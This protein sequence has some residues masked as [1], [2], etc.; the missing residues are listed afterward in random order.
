MRIESTIRKLYL[1]DYSVCAG[2]IG[3]ERIH[4]ELL[5][6]NAFGKQTVPFDIQ[7][8]GRAEVVRGYVNEFWTSRQRAAHSLHEV[9]YRACFKPQLP[10]F[11]ID[12]LTRPG[13]VVYDP[14]MGRGTTVLETA[15]K[16][17]VAIGSDLNPL[18]V[19]LVRPRLRPPSMGEV[20]DRLGELDLRTTESV[21]EE[22]LVFYHRETLEEIWALRNYLMCREAAGE[23][24]PV[25]DW[26]RMVAINR[27][28]GHSPGFFS[29]YSLPPNQA[30]S[31]ASQRRINARL[32]Q[33]PPKRDVRSLILRKT[34]SLLRDSPDG[35][36]AEL[37][38][39]PGPQQEF[40]GARNADAHRLLAKSADNTPELP[41]D[42]V[43]LSVTSPPFLDI[44]DYS[45]DNWLRGW[46]CGIDTK[47]L[48]LA[49]FRSLEAWNAFMGK[50]FVEIARVLVPG[51]Y[52]AFEVGEIRK[53]T[54]RLEE[55][56][57]RLGIEAGLDPVLLVINDQKFTKT[58]H[59]WGVDNREK[60]TNTNRI[61]LFRKTGA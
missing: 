36:Q 54:V 58:A 48:D 4:E 42:S 29:V 24:D 37:F 17:R 61:V 6:F 5:E 25:D 23:V 41:D 52:L 2:F 11:F 15:L 32:K 56:V 43:H 26:I 22:L 38:A 46:F 14:F 33:E 3:N 31:I 12:R 21:P 7:V 40:I 13:D 9:S 51:G 55:S 59:C 18:S 20:S 53:G 45:G 47:N 60:G 35:F 34:R 10:G 8:V 1:E 16:H 27:L 49:V 57:L 50:V 30:A 39:M 44:V 19:F 28:S